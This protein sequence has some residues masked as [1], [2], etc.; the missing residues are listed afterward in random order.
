MCFSLSFCVSFSSSFSSLSIS[1]EGGV[2]DHRRRQLYRNL[3]FPL[4]LSLFLDNRRYTTTF[5]TSHIVSLTFPFFSLQSCIEDLVEQ[6]K[7]QEGMMQEE[8][9]KII[10]KHE[11]LVFLEILILHQQQQGMILKRSHVHFPSDFLSNASLDVSLH[12]T[13]FLPLSLSLSVF[14]SHSYHDLTWNES[15]GRRYRI[16]ESGRSV[17]R[18]S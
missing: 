1:C 5:T 12:V 13:L 2:N 8:R 18:S 3:S 4:S 16:K 14:T 10:R 17:R 15:S 7:E 9:K 11:R 6:M